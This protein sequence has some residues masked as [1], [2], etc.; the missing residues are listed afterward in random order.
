MDSLFRNRC[1]RLKPCRERE[2]ARLRDALVMGIFSTFAR[3]DSEIDQTSS[4]GIIIDVACVLGL[5]LVV[6]CAHSRGG[7]GMVVL[8]DRFEFGQCVR[9]LANAIPFP[10]RSLFCLSIH[11]RCLIPTMKRTL[12]HMEADTA[13]PLHLALWNRYVQRERLH[14]LLEGLDDV[15]DRLRVRYDARELT[16]AYARSSSKSL[17]FPDR[18]ASCYF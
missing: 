16:Y 10:I 1:T 13:M 4:S 6:R 15:L 2:V 8:F 3:W 18:C 9:T 17:K 14:D 12:E 5:P 11:A 7:C